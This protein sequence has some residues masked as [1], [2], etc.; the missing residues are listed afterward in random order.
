[1]RL[2]R[3]SAVVA[4]S[5]SPHFDDPLLSQ[6]LESGVDYIGA[7]GSRKTHAERLS[8]FKKEGF[9]TEQL[10]KIHGPICSDYLGFL[11]PPD[12]FVPNFYV[13]FK[14]FMTTFESLAQLNLS[15]I[16]PGHCG[17]FADKEAVRFMD[18]ARKEM[19]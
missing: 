14:D 4:L 19:D 6:A 9:A 5:H 18:R 2:H 8:R 1:M 3:E 12:T 15:W 17:T 10:N 13:D 16:C 7:L 11:V